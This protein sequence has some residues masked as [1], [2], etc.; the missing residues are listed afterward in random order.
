MEFCKDNA[1]LNLARQKQE[2]LEEAVEKQ[3]AVT[4]SSNYENEMAKLKRMLERLNAAQQEYGK[5]VKT[6]Y[7]GVL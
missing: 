3:I 6:N 5:C 4:P 2:H 1:D 7:H